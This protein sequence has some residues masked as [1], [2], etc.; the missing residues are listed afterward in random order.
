MVDYEIRPGTRADVEEICGK[1]HLPG[2]LRCY[3]TYYR[4][5]LAAIFGFLILKH[6]HFAFCDIKENV[7]APKMTV[8]KAAKEMM[9]MLTK[10]NVRM[11]CEPH[12]SFPNAGKFLESLGWF[13]ADGRTY[14]WGV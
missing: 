6:S 3:A 7:G 9:A 8:Y 11:H 1:M 13:T 5:E 14:L 10:S 12:E 2:T 4:G